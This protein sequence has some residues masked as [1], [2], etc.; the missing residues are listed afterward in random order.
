VT[1]PYPK[2]REKK[3]S[4]GRGLGLAGEKEQGQWGYRAATADNYRLLLL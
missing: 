1:K 3:V 4:T 2:K